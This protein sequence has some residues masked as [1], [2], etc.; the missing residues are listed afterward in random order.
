VFDPA[1]VRTGRLGEMAVGVQQ[2]GFIG[3]ALLRFAAGDD[4]AELVGGL[5]WE[6]RVAGRHA[7]RDGGQPR[8]GWLA[9]L[10]GC[11]RVQGE[12]PRG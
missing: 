8:C 10:D 7:E 11:G 3:T 6:K 1:E 4:L 9:R 5:V 2:Q 12:Q